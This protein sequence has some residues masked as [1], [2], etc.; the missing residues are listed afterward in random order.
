MGSKKW[1]N[2]D[3]LVTAFDDNLI[4]MEAVINE[5]S[6]YTDRAEHKSMAQ[7]RTAENPHN[8][9]RGKHMRQSASEAIIIA[10]ALGL[11]E[12][13]PYIGMLLHDAGQPFDSHEGEKTN[14]I[15]GEILKIGYFHHNAKGVE[16]VIDEDLIPKFIDAIPEA[17]DNKELQEK[18][19]NDIW[20]FLEVVVGHDGEATSKENERFAKLKENFGSIK[21]RVLSNV[22]KANR[23]NDYKCAVQTLEAQI[24][25]PADILAYMRTDAM[26]GFSE[27]ILTELSDDYLVVVSKLLTETE[28]E[29]L[30]IENS[31][32]QADAERKEQLIEQVRKNRISKAKELINSIKASKLRAT[33]DEILSETENEILDEL[34]KYIDKLKQNNIDISDI[35]PEDIEKVEEIK[36]KIINEFKE[37]SFAKI[38]D[39]DS[40]KARVEKNKVISQTDKLDEYMNKMEITRKRVVEE[41][42]TKMQTALR[43]DYIQSTLK[44]WEEI[45]NNENLTDEE[46]YALKKQGMDF[47]EKVNKIIYGRNGIKDLNYREYVQYSKKVY[48]TGCK[49]KATYELV[50]RCAKAIQ[51]T[52]VIRSKFYDSEVLKHIENEE[53]IDLMQQEDIDIDKNKE[54]RRKIGIIKDKINNTQE[55]TTMEGRYTNKEA[56]QKMERNSLYRAIYRHIQMQEESFARSTEDV[57]YAIPNTVRNMVE[58]AIR[59][60]YDEDVYL[61]DSEREEVNKIKRELAAR[62]GES[63]SITTENLEAYINEQIQKEREQIELKVATLMCRDYLAG[64]TNEGM[65]TL[66]LETGIMSQEEFDREN[67]PNTEGNRVVQ[68]LSEAL[69]KEDEEDREEDHS[70]QK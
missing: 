70:M 56:K 65:N 11:N 20:Y 41:L 30:Q 18:L 21:E 25:R 53:L 38:S 50:Q 55:P 17:K 4:E 44:R 52:G 15:I 5:R 42:L 54:Y 66:L 9:S 68:Q 60:E 8:T 59:P 13:V 2:R 14:N 37:R 27:K 63:E 12:V 67:V 19:K 43:E 28:E 48:L 51:K 3:A 32:E 24:A 40:K 34:N 35:K 64:K 46:R 31:I 36:S 69:R 26:T 6:K 22:S 57:Y 1:K 58:K 16:V 23:T 39:K 62:F 29:T 45:E 7:G 61:P 49:P 10:R 33:R 47:S